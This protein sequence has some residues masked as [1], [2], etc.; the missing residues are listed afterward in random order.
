M[1]FEMTLQLLEILLGT[2]RK[3]R[4]HLR[5]WHLAP[6]A[7]DRLLQNAQGFRGLLILKRQR[8]LAR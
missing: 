6:V 5:R 4:F 8:Q 7:A 2:L 3:P 1:S